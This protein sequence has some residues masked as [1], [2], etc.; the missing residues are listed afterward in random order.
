MEREGFRRLLLWFNEH[1][2]PIR[3]VNSDRHAHFKRVMDEMNEL[4]SWDMKWHFDARHL[5]RYLVK[6]LQEDALPDP[7]ISCSHN[8]KK[9]TTLCR[10]LL[11]PLHTISSPRS[12]SIK[13]FRMTKKF[14]L[15]DLQPA[16]LVF[17][18]CRNVHVTPQHFTNS[19][20]K[21]PLDPEDDDGIGSFLLSD[22][23]EED[24]EMYF[25]VCPTERALPVPLITGS[26]IT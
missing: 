11:E 18:I 7:Y 25:E 4:L 10:F 2:L 23:D 14:Q 21:V 17:R 3:S 24:I 12:C 9:K 15:S 26:Y 1:G 5:S 6:A 20:I 19:G 13:D 22:S 16:V 8:A